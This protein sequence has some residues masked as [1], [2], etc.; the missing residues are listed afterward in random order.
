MKKAQDN[1]LVRNPHGVVV[2]VGESELVDIR[3]RI[4]K[5]DRF[6]ILEKIATAPIATSVVHDIPQPKKNPY[7]CPICGLTK[8]TPKEIR[9]H[10]KYK[11]PEELAKAEKEVQEKNG[12][13]TD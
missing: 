7:E 6:E 5:G 4:E 12:T 1:Y 8:R 10:I 2:V 3:R 9:G 13:V 11:H